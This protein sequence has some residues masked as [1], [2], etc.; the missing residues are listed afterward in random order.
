M[1]G[2]LGKGCLSISAYHMKEDGDC[3]TMIRQRDIGAVSPPM[4]PAN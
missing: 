2:P 4:F 1:V 3:T